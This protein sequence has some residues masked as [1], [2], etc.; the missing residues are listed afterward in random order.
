MMVRIISALFLALA[1]SACTSGQNSTFERLKPIIENEIFGGP[2]FGDPPPPPEPFNP[3]R[4]ELNEVP[5]ATIAVSIE[6]SPRTFVVPLADN[7]GYLIYQD[8][9]RRGIVMRGGLI[10]ATQGLSYNLSAV[11]HDLD[12]PVIAPRALSRWPE[13]IFRNYQFALS[14]GARDFQITVACS[15][16]PG[17]PERIEIIELFFDTIRVEEVCSNTVRE[18]R[19]TYWV[20]PN[21]G[22]IWKSEQWIGPRQQPMTVEII[23]PYS[24]S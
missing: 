9:F 13:S 2:I 17:T 14:G 23:R 1:L 15:Y 4:A 12:D 20:D 11:K 7:G 5:F 6:D 8:A 21:S 18:F 16:R 22:F 10:T 19:N 3:T 24:A